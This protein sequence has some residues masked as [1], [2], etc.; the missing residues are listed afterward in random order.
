MIELDISQILTQLLAF[1]IM[2]AVL[3]RYGWK[4]IAHLLDQR[5]EKIAAEF[6]TIETQK[7]QL[8]KLIENYNM[9]LKDIDAEIRLKEQQE[10]Q[11]WEK[12][13]ALCMEEAKK[14]AKELIAKASRDAE[15]QKG[16][17]AGELK[18]ELAEWVVMASEKVLGEELKNP[19]QQKR[20]AEKCLESLEINK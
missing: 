18:K 3:K 9:K 6:A 5:K 20:F 12:A 17:A 10:R 8:K 19:E 4:P 15:E 7:T 1:L 14:E 16:K 13:A 11:K 2:L